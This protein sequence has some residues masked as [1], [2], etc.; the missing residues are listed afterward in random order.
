MNPALL[1]LLKKSKQPAVGILLAGGVWLAGRVDL[2]VAKVDSKLERIEGRIAA[3]ER[4]LNL[5]LAKQ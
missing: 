4:A 2:A 1:E 3:V 5:P